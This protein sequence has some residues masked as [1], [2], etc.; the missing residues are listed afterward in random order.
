[1]I[2]D[3]HRKLADLA[4][5]TLH[6]GKERRAK[7]LRALER[8]YPMLSMATPKKGLDVHKLKAARK[9]HHWSQTKLAKKCDM[10]LRQYQNV[11]TGKTG[12]TRR[13]MLLLADAL[14]LSVLEIS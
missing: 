13:R 7:F 4:A 14:G 1:M 12:T 8:V 9:K 11:E 5:H 3:N 6:L 10:S 2:T